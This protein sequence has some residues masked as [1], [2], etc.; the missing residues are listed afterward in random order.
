MVQSLPIFS[1][2]PCE[3]RHKLRFHPRQLSVL[4]SL[5]ATI[6]RLEMDGPKLPMGPSREPDRDNSVRPLNR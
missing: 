1:D 5:A 3:W 6:R 2:I 4:Y